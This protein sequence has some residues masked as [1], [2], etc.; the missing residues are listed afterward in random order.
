MRLARGREY[1]PNPYSRV[2]QRLTSLLGARQRLA[3]TVISETSTEAHRPR[4]RSRSS[5]DSGMLVSFVSCG[6]VAIDVAVLI[7]EL[8]ICLGIFYCQVKFFVL[9]IFYFRSSG[10]I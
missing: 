4:I 9:G 3:M 7:T 6:C 10:P 5:G 2:Q 1:L 8:S